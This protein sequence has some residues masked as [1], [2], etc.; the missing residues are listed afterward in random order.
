MTT[1]LSQ[2]TLHWDMGTFYPGLGLRLGPS[3]TGI[4]ILEFV[5]DP[6]RE[7]LHTVKEAS[8]GKFLKNTG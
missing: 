3:H 5:F 8:T 4:G 7:S 1:A 6:I 2:R